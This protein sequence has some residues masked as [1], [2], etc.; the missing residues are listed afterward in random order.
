MPTA[1]PKSIMLNVAESYD[2]LADMAEQRRYPK[3]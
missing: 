2:R 1:H 3:G